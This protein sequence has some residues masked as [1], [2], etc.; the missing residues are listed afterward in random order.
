MVSLSSLT[1]GGGVGSASQKGSSR[2]VAPR[3]QEAY[4]QAL[5]RDGAVAPAALQRAARHAADFGI[6]LHE[7]VVALGLL[8]EC[9]SY[10]R[11]AEVAGIPYI[12]AQDVV[13]SSLALR[14]VPA[15]VAW[16][17]E[18]LPIAVDDRRITYL[19]STP[20]NLEA[21][22]D[23]SFTSG[24]IPVAALSCASH[25]RGAIGRHYPRQAALETLLASTRSA[26]RVEFVDVPSIDTP[27]D[28]AVVDL[29]NALVAQAVDSGA[30][31]LHLDPIETGIVVRLRIGG[32]LELGPTIGA[33]L[34]PSVRN[35]FKIMARLDIT[36][37]HRPQDGAFRVR[38]RGRDIDV[39]LSTLPTTAGEKLVMRIIDS[40]SDLRSLDRLGYPDE[41]LARLKRVLDRPDGLVLVTGPTGSGKTT[42]LYAALHYLRNGRVNIVSVEDPVERRLPGVNQI[43]VNPRAGAT[44]ASVLRSV[45]RQDPN[46]VMVG[47]I[48]DAEVAQIVGQAA[49]TGHLVLSSV[50]TI[51]TATAVMRLLNLGLE[52]FRVAE[53]L[54]GILAQRLVRRLCP[55][56]SL[57]GGRDGTPGP[58]CA[59]CGET[60]YVDRVPIAE[61]L[62]PTDEI[63]SAIARG[64]TAAEI[65]L[66]MREAGMPSMR[67]HARAMVEAG[68][69]TAAEIARVLGDT[70]E[71][72]ESTP[73]RR[74]PL[75][76]IADDEPITR[77]LVRLLLERD[78]YAV[79]EVANGRQAVE[80][81]KVCRPAL[82]VMDLHMPEM[83]GF[84]AVTALRRIP[85]LAGVPIVVVTAEQGPGVERQVLALGA[86]D[87]IVKPFEPSLLA[88]RI[89][90]VFAR[91]QLAA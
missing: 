20:Y 86:D 1:I 60:G 74:R 8:D 78:G 44:F 9:V 52:P 53:T 21:D 33:D 18:V 48:R 2:V 45:L 19:T 83:S 90:A 7:A 59:H 54:T 67:D 68:I 82:V 23:V 6:P 24:R 62:T 26:A 49:Y 73:S 61:L 5:L 16:R 65:R 42:A 39:R 77:T 55:E 47:E 50:H 70:A 22:K 58:G 14:L 91:Q 35:R 36:V 27:S 40:R 56:C 57:R 12:E 71:S 30:S 66:A 41:L 89:K 11:L 84:E 34:A 64:A 79:V 72:S 10:R 31:D 51:D 4:A 37:R 38:F 3:L 29:C 28:S 17:H 80:Q 87:Y 88:G 76:L 13:P 32:V 46:V 43:P 85:E 63:R 25:L 15:R 81:A 69:T 75:V